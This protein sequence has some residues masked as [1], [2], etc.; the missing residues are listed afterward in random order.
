MQPIISHFEN[1]SKK[2]LVIQFVFL[3]I[4]LA[5]VAMASF[6]T[7]DYLVNNKDV[8]LNP[9]PGTTITIGERHG[10]EP[11]ISKQIASTSV[12]KVIRIHVGSY[13]V[14]FSASRDYEPQTAGVDINDSTEITTPSLNYTDEKLASLLDAEKDN[15]HNV[16]WG[17][18]PKDK[19]DISNE[20]LFYTGQWYSATLTP[21][22]W[23][24]PTVS[25]NLI[26][27]PTNDNNTLDTLRVVLKKQGSSWKMFAGPSVI[28]YI[29]D[30]PQIPQDIIRATNAL[31][32]SLD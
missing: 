23:Y 13:A 10:D 8:T 32:F 18:V 4:L 31:G 27:R 21:K 2:K 19:Y 11:V 1:I 25:A 28:L 7:W 12:K 30:H 20:K 16:I 15:V 9:T 17:V 6:F 26:P 3:I 22:D 29:N 24:D 5:L 14:K